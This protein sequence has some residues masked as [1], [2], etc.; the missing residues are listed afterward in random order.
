MDKIR[1]VAACCC[2][3]AANLQAA[4]N[5]AWALAAMSAPAVPPQPPAN[6]TPPP[7]PGA[8]GQ[9]MGQVSLS[10]S[11]KTDYQGDYLTFPI[12]IGG[13]KITGV[14]ATGVYPTA[15][16]CLPPG[17]HLQGYASTNDGYLFKVNTVPS[18]PN[19]A[20]VDGC[21]SPSTP[22]VAG[23]MVDVTSQT[24][25]LF[26]PNRFGWSYGALAIPF[27]MELGKSNDVQASATLGPY[28]GYTFDHET[29]GLSFTP[30]IFIG[31]TIFSNTKASSSASSQT[32]S[33]GTGF[34]LSVG[35]GVTVL[36]KD[37][38][39]LGFVAGYDHAGSNSGY[40]YNDHFWVSAAVGFGFN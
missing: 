10:A 5:P 9:Q 8:S 25:T 18:A 12:W 11:S 27:K 39:Q 40:S 30:L 23:D 36:I 29:A 3:I 21:Q 16:T 24:M 4:V 1:I 28:F 37:S 7:N 35:T 38:F 17:T 19:Y 33:A 20:K 6:P 31:P 26:P 32:S 22:P 14:N 34:G 13:K 15:D 2:V